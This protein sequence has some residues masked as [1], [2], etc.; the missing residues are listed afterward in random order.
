MKIR[1]HVYASRK[2]YLYVNKKV[3][4]WKLDGKSLFKYKNYMH[5]SKKVIVW[6]LG[7]TFMKT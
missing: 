4:A 1:K 2:V 3:P 6:I 5:E 7:S